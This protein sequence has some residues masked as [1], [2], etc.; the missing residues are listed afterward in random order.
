M[1]EFTQ[2]IAED[3]KTFTNKKECLKYEEKIKIFLSEPSS[4]QAYNEKGEQIFPKDYLED[5]ASFFA[6]MIYIKIFDIDG[7]ETFMY[8]A[9]ENFA[10]WI[11]IDDYLNEI[12]ET[13]L[14]Y[15]DE[16]DNEFKR[17]ETELEKLEEIRK[18]VNYL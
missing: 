11:C 5:M 3:G 1:K 9:D 4:F 18:K 16:N 6:E 10:L 14:Y 15:Y 12:S 17:L 2:Y 7:W 13:G 8:W